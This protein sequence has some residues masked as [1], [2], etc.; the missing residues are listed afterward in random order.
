[1]ITDEK[2]DIIFGWH[3][4]PGFPAGS[5]AVHDGTA[6]FASRGLVLSFSEKLTRFSTRKRA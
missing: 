3:N 2:P 5:V 1:M 6:A 4:M